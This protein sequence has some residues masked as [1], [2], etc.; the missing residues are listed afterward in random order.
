MAN[1]RVYKTGEYQLKNPEKYK[2]S[3]T[4]LYKSSFEERV[5]YWC[6]ENTNVLE[7]TYEPFPV[8]YIFET[9][10]NA[11]DH[12]KALCDGKSHRYYP[13][14]VAKIKTND[15]PK[16]YLLEIKPYSQT[17]KPTEPKKKTKKALKTF[18]TALQEFLKNAK[19][20]E[21]ARIYA[22]QRDM[23]FVVLTERDIFT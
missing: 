9:S 8:E 14:L 17:V 6:D 23:E 18:L 4:P 5:F 19:K 7:W 21:A 1:N 15:G 11:P 2:G 20:W 3:K 22:R 16:M 13:D 12:E 10:K